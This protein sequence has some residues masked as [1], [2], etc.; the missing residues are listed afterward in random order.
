MPLAVALREIMAVAGARVV[1]VRV[2]DHRAV[3]RPP[4]IDVEIARRAVQALG[5][6]MTRS[7]DTPP[8]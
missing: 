7:R 2:R 1:A 3:D 4:G 8:A 6:A 5:R